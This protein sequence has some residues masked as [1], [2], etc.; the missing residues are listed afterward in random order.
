MKRVETPEFSVEVSPIFETVRIFG[1][2]IG[3]KR[4]PE[5]TF[6]P[7]M[8]VFSTD[9]E[10]GQSPKDWLTNVLKDSGPIVER[11]AV[12]FAGMTGEITKIKD[13]LKDYETGEEKDWYRVAGIAGQFR[14]RLLVSWDG[15]GQRRRL[16]CDRGGLHATAKFHQYQT[17]RQRHQKDP[18]VP[19]QHQWRR[20]EVVN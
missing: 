17:G 20:F 4:E 9:A 2:S 19:R 5:T 10:K 13:R 3:L 7:Q 16:A 14:R 15:H 18:R 6:S 12:T 1:G 8:S 11:K